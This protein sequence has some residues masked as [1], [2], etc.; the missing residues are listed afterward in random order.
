MKFDKKNVGILVVAA[1][2]IIVGMVLFK[3]VGGK[4]NNQIDEAVTITGSFSCLP[5]KNPSPDDVCTLGVKSKDDSYYALDI[6]HI[7]DANTD[8]KAEDKIAVT[9]TIMSSSEL[10]S[11]K[12]KGY[13]IKGII[14]VSTL[15]RTR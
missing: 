6:S 5:L 8:L 3:D 9:G 2:L 10:N 4:V 7:Q 13:D 1:L 12:W 14:L 11:K 15:L